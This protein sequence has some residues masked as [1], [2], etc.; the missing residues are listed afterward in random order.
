MRGVF[1]TGTDTNVGKTIVAAACMHR[2]RDATR[3]RYWKPV[4]TGIE[5]DDD[6]ATVRKLGACLDEEIL[7]V[8]VRL[9]RPLSPHLA[10][11][12]E[13]ERIE[14]RD[15]LRLVRQNSMDRGWVIEGAG[16]VMVPLNETD[17]V[18][19]LM[20]QLAL[21]VIIA[22][23]SGL[24]TINH[25]LLTLNNVRSRGLQTAGVVMVGVADHNNRKAIEHYGEVAVLGEMP[26]FESLTSSILK[27][28]AQAELDPD[29]LL[30]EIFK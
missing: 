29:N 13:R 16:G 20:E 15:L 11:Q 30:E 7:N 12:L 28:W 18:I 24:G 22:A 27:R 21:P 25:T 1:V 4:Q 3:L 19:D 9:P 6:T 8:G 2:Y 23:R 5:Q 14:V 17:L 10:A 26:H